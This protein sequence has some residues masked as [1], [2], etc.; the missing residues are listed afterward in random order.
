MDDFF[1]W[2]KTLD[3]SNVCAA[4]WTFVSVYGVSLITIVIGNIKLKA[5]NANFNEKLSKLEAE[6]IVE[7]N[8]KLEEFKS[9][10]HEEF[11][12]LKENILNDNIKN[13]QEKIEAVNN[14]I[15]EAKQSVSDLEP[16]NFDIDKAL[17]ELL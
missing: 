1:N 2:L 7:Y 3:W 11:D 13:N 4:I 10:F 8:K 6:L 9:L 12:D 17:K 5:K 15:E 14:A 16:V